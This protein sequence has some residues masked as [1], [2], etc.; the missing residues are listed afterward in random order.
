MNDMIVEKIWFITMCDVFSDAEILKR[1]NDSSLL[2]FLMKIPRGGRTNQEQEV[3]VKTGYYTRFDGM[4][5]VVL[6]FSTDVRSMIVYRYCQ[7]LV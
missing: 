4:E 5:N 6:C 7:N 2:Y 1:S 3:I